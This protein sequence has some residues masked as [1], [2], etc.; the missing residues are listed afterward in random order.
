MIDVNEQ[1]KHPEPVKHSDNE[2]SKMP[3]RH[4]DPNRP[5]KKSSEDEPPVE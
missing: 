2:K 5:A 1:F 3:P 4:D